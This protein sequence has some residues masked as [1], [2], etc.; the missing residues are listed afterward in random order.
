MFIA[1]KVV[2]NTKHLLNFTSISVGVDI[3]YFYFKT[4]RI[5]IYHINIFCNKLFENIRTLY[6]PLVCTKKEKQP[7]K[8]I[9]L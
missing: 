2:I 9:F 7:L 3:P 4:K 6:F 8:Q 1:Y 5:Y